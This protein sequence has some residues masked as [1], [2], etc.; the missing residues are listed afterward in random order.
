[1]PPSEHR[2]LSNTLHHTNPT[3]A[4]GSPEPLYYR[5]KLKGISQSQFSVS[6]FST[7][8]ELWVFETNAEAWQLAFCGN[9][10]LLKV[11]IM[12]KL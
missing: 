2:L 3:T 12:A 7:S 8:S 1:V 6:R 10:N 5:R 4:E 11:N 9:I